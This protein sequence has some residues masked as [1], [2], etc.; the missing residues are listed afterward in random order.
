MHE[1]YTFIW[2]NEQSVLLEVI[3]VTSIMLHLL[4]DLSWRLKM[5]TQNLLRLLPVLILMLDTVDG[6]LVKIW[7]L[8]FGHKVKVLFKL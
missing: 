6:S 5:P 1:F 4:S 2:L 7:K 8:K 3:E